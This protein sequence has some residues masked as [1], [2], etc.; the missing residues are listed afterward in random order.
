MLLVTGQVE[1]V[2]EREAGKP[3]NT[4]I[5]HTLVVK[6]WGQTLYVTCV[7]DFVKAGLPQKGEN[8]ALDVAVRAYVGRDEKPGHGYSAFRRN[9]E[10]EAKLF[11]AGERKLAA[12][13]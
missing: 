5:E 1:D 3:G 8:V 2:R 9:T 13:Q 6:D 7:A 12:A 4:W 11:G 10:A